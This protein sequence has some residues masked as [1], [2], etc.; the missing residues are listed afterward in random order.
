MHKFSSQMTVL[1]NEDLFLHHKAGFEAKTQ[2]SG[3]DFSIFIYPCISVLWV[4]KYYRRLL[5][6][7]LEQSL[8]SIIIEVRF[9]L[10]PN[11]SM[12]S[13]HYRAMWLDLLM[14]PRKKKEFVS[15]TLLMAQTFHVKSHTSEL[16]R[17]SAWKRKKLIKR[18]DLYISNNL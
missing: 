13:V 10:T 11:L 4:C 17:L 15:Q 12:G 1:F 6:P 5:E 7:T 9:K 2:N 8:Q 18:C 14:N 16:Q 3:L